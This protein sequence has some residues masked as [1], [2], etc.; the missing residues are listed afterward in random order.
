[1]SQLTDFY[2]CRAPDSEGRYLGQILDCSDEELETVDDYIQWLFPV[3]EP[4][5][6][7]RNAP[8]LTKEDIAAFQG[9]LTLQTHLYKSFVRIL[10]FL[11]LEID[12]RGVVESDN[13]WE[14]EKDV[15]S[16]PNHN[17]FRVTRILRSLSLLGFR[18]QARALFRWLEAAYTS[19][20]YP[21]T[22]ET[23][24]Y[25]SEAVGH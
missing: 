4:S 16:Y 21:I 12:F 20:K 3:P 23:F 11:G 1:M 24:G 2:A 14:R 5:Q 13:F 9:D 22:E 10:A 18:G 19:R 17:W 25:W 6:F 7:N 8:L 15:W